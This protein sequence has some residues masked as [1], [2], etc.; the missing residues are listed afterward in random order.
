MT[1]E[2]LTHLIEFCSL[3]IVS[4]ICIT[5][6]RKGDSGLAIVVGVFNFVIAMIILLRTL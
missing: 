4:T 1:N 6:H 5:S 3:V 2:Y